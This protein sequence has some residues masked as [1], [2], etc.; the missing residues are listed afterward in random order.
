VPKD[1]QEALHAAC[2][3]AVAR[4]VELVESDDEGVA[5][6]ASTRVIERMLGKVPQPLTNDGDSPFRVQ[7]SDARERLAQRIS[8][9]LAAGGTGGAAGGTD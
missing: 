4:L 7:V 8:A 9:L 3:R 6:T 1:I 5:L 2:P